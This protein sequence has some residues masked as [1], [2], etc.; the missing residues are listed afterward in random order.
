MTHP[1]TQNDA[2]DA[3]ANDSRRPER[4]ESLP[5]DPT[6]NVGL[7]H[8]TLAVSEGLPLEA[9]TASGCGGGQAGQQRVALTGPDSERCTMIVP[10]VTAAEFEVAPQPTSW[11]L[12][13]DDLPRCEIKPPT[14][15]SVRVAQRRAVGLL[16][17]LET[18][19]TITAAMRDAGRSFQAQFRAA[20]LDPL[21]AAPLVRIDARRSDT[22]T[23]WA[24]N[25]RSR[26]MAALIALGGV[27]SAAG[28]CVWHVVG[29]EISIRAWAAREGWR[30]KPVGHAQAQGMLVAALGVL[31]GHY[32]RAETFRR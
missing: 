16:S 26:V 18:N 12:Q 13:H 24:E 23:E 11:R 22:Q 2:L 32:G 30:G 5:L 8:A 7:K 4:L 31:A 6:I 3:L 15:A 21:R 27:E 1:L 25:A 10:K 19:G 29:C 28:S 20:A 9:G 17:R 14:G